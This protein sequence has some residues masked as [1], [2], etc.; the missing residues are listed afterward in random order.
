MSDDYR[1][2]ETECK[3]IRE[4]NAQLLEGFAAWLRNARLTEKTLNTHVE[5]IDLYINEFLLYE[6][7]VKAKDGTHDVSM[8][9][10]YWFIKKAMWAS[11]AHIKRYAASLK[12]LYTFL[13]EQGLIAQQELDDLKEIIKA[14]MPEWIATMKRYDDESITD[15][16]E[17]WGL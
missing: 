14:D 7:A 1:K 5:N 11:P 12:K 3:K 9:L 4:E 6:D 8:F 2:Y 16:D 17:V 13:C 15:M 10:G